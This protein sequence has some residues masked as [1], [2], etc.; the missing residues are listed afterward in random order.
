MNSELFRPVIIRKTATL[1][2][3]VANTKKT[4]ITSYLQHVGLTHT[5]QCDNDYHTREVLVWIRLFVALSRSQCMNIFMLSNQTR[6]MRPNE[7]KKAETM[8]RM[9]VETQWQ[10]EMTI[11]LCQSN[12]SPKIISHMKKGIQDILQ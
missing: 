9:D 2:E 1:I 6:K 4:S 11:M 5:I 7:Q 8:F 12:V 10:I 3:F